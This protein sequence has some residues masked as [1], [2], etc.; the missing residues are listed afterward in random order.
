MATG[1]TQRAD[2]L[3]D[4]LDHGLRVVFCGTAA[5]AVSATR[6]AYYAGPGNR[7]WPTLYAVGLITEPLRPQAY[8]RLLEW[9]L[10]LTDLVKGT[11]GQDAELPRQAYDRERLLR[12]LARYRPHVV[13]F[14]SKRAGA[15]ALGLPSA[16]LAYGFQGA[17]FGAVHVFV[18][19]SPSGAARRYWDQRPWQAL[20][21][22]VS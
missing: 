13:A 5:S 3:P 8:P 16:S 10:G 4:L 2:V 22:Y 18:L 11:S 6:R 19:P 9:G 7:F 15:V 17:C 1:G 20:A 14:T 21:N 12:A